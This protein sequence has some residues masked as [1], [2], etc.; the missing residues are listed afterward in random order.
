MRTAGT[1]GLLAALAAVAAAES[2]TLTTESAVH[3]ALEHSET[4]RI[5][6][7]VAAQSHHQVRE[8]RADGLPGLSASADYT[9]NWLLPSFVFNNTAVK[10]GR[11][12]EIQ[13]LL[14][15]SQPLYTGGRATGR[16]RSARG[17]AEASD[18]AEDQ[19]R[20]AVTAQVER[21]LYDYLLA[22]D[23]VQVSA[24][25]L[26]RARSNQRQVDAFGQAGRASRFE[27]MRA[28]V[29]VAAA[30]SDSIQRANEQ[31]VALMALKDAIGL[32][33]GT[34]VVVTAPFREATQLSLDDVDRLVADALQARPERRQLQALRQ[35]REGDLQVAR[36]GRR[37]TVDAVALGQVQYQ[38]DAFGDI[39]RGEEWRRSWST[40]LAVEVPLFDGLRARSRVA[41]A[42]EEVRRLDLEASRLDRAIEREV[43]EAW[44][45]VAEAGQRLAARE[46]S[47]DQ[48]RQGLQDAE[49]RYRA[50]RG[51]QLEVL[52]AQLALVQAESEVARARR[53]RALALVALEQAT[54]VL[55][56]RAG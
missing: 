15:A 44:M 56:E 8:A 22:R 34:D 32:D 2:L 33:I 43:R 38:S 20:Q 45:A 46:G 52:D 4:V 12:N 37:P 24:T 19:V 1:W 31:A 49:S 39:D 47:V 3:L 17:L 14:R 50:G 42:E 51:T 29:Q 18:R 35:A 40:G 9:R 5:A 23:M 55:G 41:Q 53:D 27:L 30:V 6:G 28:A 10:I 16:L 13:G 54:G 21:A 25:A 11:D 48:A 7:R 26:A 36:A